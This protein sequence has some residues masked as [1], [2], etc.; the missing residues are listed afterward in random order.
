MTVLAAPE[1]LELE[2]DDDAEGAGF[3]CVAPPTG[4]VALAVAA[5][6]ATDEADAILSEQPPSNKLSDAYQGRLGVSENKPEHSRRTRRPL[7]HLQIQQHALN[8]M[9]HPILN[10]HVA[11]R[12]LRAREPARDDVRSGRVR[13]DGEGFARAG[14]VVRRG[15][16]EEERGVEGFADD[17][18][19]GHG[20]VSTR[21]IV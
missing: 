2:L 6:E 11:L 12:D 16:G 3:A 18:L 1:E 20:G 5:A 7:I 15:G 19:L 8:N 9:H 13:G 21:W 14:G 4:P 10:Q 17:D